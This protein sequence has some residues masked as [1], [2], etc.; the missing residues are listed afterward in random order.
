MDIRASVRKSLREYRML[1]G[2][3][4]IICAFSG[5]PDSVCLAAVLMSLAP[6]LGFRLECAHFN[7]QLRGEE[8]RRDEEFAASWCAERG[9][10][11]RVGRGDAAA[12]A[13][14]RRLGI[15][16]A[17]RI[18][19]YG[20]LESLGDEKTRIATAHQAD[21]QA[22]T[23]LINLVR[24]SG[25]KGLGGIPP[26]RDRLIRPLLDVSRSEILSYLDENHLRYVEDSSNRDTRYRRNRLRM[27]VLPVLKEMNPAFAKTC[28]RTAKLLRED[29]ELL[30]RQAA[31]AVNKEGECAVLSVRE[32]REMPG[33][34]AS[35]SIRQAAVAYGIRLEEIHVAAVREL[36]EAENPSARLELPGGL[37]AE[38]KYERLLIGRLN[39]PA[40]FSETALQFGA[41]RDIPESGICVFW[42]QKSE[43]A[44]IHGKFTTFF[45]KMDQICGNIT[46]RPRREGDFLK[47]P[48]RPGK[49]LKKWLI[50][51]KVPLT[52]RSRLP[53]FADEAGV[54]A[55]FGLGADE[56]AAASEA[57]ADSVLVIMERT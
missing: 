13:A 4:R 57:S 11:L 48:G 3:D 15:E 8:S 10:K 43:L 50:Q 51:E 44:K 6:E 24:G 9:L 23:M 52:E 21:D 12:F 7:H 34:L 1:S 54:L 17:A 18:L 56:R 42:G 33:P 39:R 53:V 46:V 27:E 32:L 2:A 30:A 22:E 25:L 19:R 47:L 37:T 5:G 28:S 20:F 35:R 14:E 36:A 26:V 49:S 29:E 40:A 55:V 31:D 38:R 16:E 41:W 45:F